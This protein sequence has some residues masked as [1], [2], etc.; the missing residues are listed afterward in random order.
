MKAILIALLLG[1][2]AA[3]QLGD[4]LARFSYSG[5]LAQRMNGANAAHASAG[6]P[7]FVVDGAQ[8]R[9]LAGAQLL[10]AIQSL[11]R[12]FPGC[13]NRELQ[14]AYAYGEAPAAYTIAF[15]QATKRAP[16]C[17]A[18]VTVAVS[19]SGTVTVRSSPDS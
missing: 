13:G 7:R 3:A 1:L 18:T 8:G 11:I 19:T 15:S 10:G 14:F 5:D 12:A 16:E 4:P 2:G 17:P 9:G 6:T